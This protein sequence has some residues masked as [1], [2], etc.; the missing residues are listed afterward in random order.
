MTWL[1]FVLGSLSCYRLTRLVTADEIT[2]PLRNW[3]FSKGTMFGYLASCDWCLSIWVSPFVAIPIT[4]WP[5]N[6]LTLATLLA[7]SLSA[8]TGLV[9]VTEQRIER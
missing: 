5:D 6:N 4:L 8:V 3:A 1:L 7:L 9:S 2:K